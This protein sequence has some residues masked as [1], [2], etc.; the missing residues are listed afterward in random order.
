MSEWEWEWPCEDVT[1]RFSIRLQTNLTFT[2]C[3][4][5]VKLDNAWIHDIAGYS[6]PRLNYA[7]W[8]QNHIAAPLYDGTLLWK[9]K[10]SH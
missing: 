10:K 5:A 9:V 8:G 6:M 3:K 4:S 7:H 2:E 1:V